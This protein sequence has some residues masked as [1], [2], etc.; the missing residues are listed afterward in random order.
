MKTTRGFLKALI[1]LSASGLFFAGC[2]T[3]TETVSERWAGGNDDYAY[4]DTTSSGDTTSASY[5]DDDGYRDSQYHMAF[6]YYYPPPDY[7]ASAVGYDPWFDYN[8]Y[9]W[10]LWYPYGFGF[11]WGWGYGYGYGYGY[12][13]YY[14]RGYHGWYGGRNFA[15]RQRTIGSGRGSFGY[16]AGR[17]MPNVPGRG[18]SAGE[19]AS[20]RARTTGVQASNPSASRAR[21]EVPWWQRANSNAVASRQAA[22]ASRGRS[23][24]NVRGN[25]YAQQMYQHRGRVQPAG[26]FSPPQS[27]QVARQGYSAPARS[28]GRA[29]GGGG[30]RGGGGGGR[31]KGR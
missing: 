6:D 16:A 21:Q 23:V 27:R 9:P 3:H 17:T 30:S 7:Y 5:Y 29:S 1:A 2:Y 15:L 12:G 8:Y 11:G 19:A 4:T 14:G 22:V 31:S 20:V 18:Y 26:R 13:G 10:G 28:S 24:A 25:P